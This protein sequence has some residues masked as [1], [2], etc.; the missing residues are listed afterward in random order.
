MADA[1]KRKKMEFYHLEQKGI[2]IGLCPFRPA[3]AV[4]CPVLHDCR[5]CGWH[6]DVEEERKKRVREMM[7]EPQVDTYAHIKRA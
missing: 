6:P 5:H 7:Q 2:A 1:Y 3:G 4:E